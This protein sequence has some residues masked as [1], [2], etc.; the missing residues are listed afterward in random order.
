ML[1][2]AMRAIQIPRLDGPQAAEL[3]ELDEPTD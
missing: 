1:N 3:V 2:G